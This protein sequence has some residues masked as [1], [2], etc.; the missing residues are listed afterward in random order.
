M[1]EL[2]SNAWGKTKVEY[3]TRAQA[4]KVA[5]K[6]K[7][8]LALRVYPCRSCGSWHLT[9]QEQRHKT[10]PIP[11]AAKLRRKLEAYGREIAAQQR[12]FDLAEKALADAKAEAEAAKQR[13][14]AA[15]IEELEWIRKAT[16]KL[17][18]R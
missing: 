10:E 16:E 6:T 18:G 17:F 14:E 5:R 9:S 4:E 8:G 12:R 3:K 15:H 11:S 13:A 1:Q 7:S 2:C